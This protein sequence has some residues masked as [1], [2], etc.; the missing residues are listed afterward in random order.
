MYVGVGLI[1]RSV[2]QGWLEDKLVGWLTEWLIPPLSPSPAADA[3][4]KH[5]TRNRPG[6]FDFTGRRKHA[7]WEAKKGERR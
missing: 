4:T 1:G 6:I 3:L 7:A 5:E 2:H